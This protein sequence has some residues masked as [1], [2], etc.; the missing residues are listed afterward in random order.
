MT[1]LPREVTLEL[2]TRQELPAFEAQF[3]ALQDKCTEL[4]NIISDT[5][6]EIPGVATLEKTDDC[7]KLEKTNGF[8]YFY[9]TDKR[10]ELVIWLEPSNNSGS[11]NLHIFGEEALVIPS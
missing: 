7:I 5:T 8:T 11:Y 2:I 3:R 1:Q 9:N 4:V 10:L 6:V